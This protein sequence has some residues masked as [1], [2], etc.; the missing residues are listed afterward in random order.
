MPTTLAARAATDTKVFTIF[1]SS[2]CFSRTLLFDTRL[3]VVVSNLR[4][5][6]TFGKFSV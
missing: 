6:F 4:K 5:Y 3:L 2:P 1:I